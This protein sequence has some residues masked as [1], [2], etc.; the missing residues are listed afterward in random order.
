MLHTKTHSF[1]HSACFKLFPQLWHPFLLFTSLL[2]LRLLFR[3]K[4]GKVS[5]PPHLQT[6]QP[7]RP[8]PPQTKTKHWDF[9]PTISPPPAP[10]LT[11]HAEE[12]GEAEDHEGG[13]PQQTPVHQLLPPGPRGLVF[14]AATANIAEPHCEPHQGRERSFRGAGVTKWP[15]PRNQET[16]V[17]GQCCSAFSFYFT[18]CNHRL[19]SFSTCHSE[20]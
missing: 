1:S 6:N 8:P 10:L 5:S 19:Q 16:P 2:N 7:L 17:S 9:L 4:C 13:V 18:D 15:D 14:C 12:G 11:D 3:W 20:P